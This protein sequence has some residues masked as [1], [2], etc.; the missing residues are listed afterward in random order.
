MPDG[1]EPVTPIALDSCTDLHATLRVSGGMGFTDDV[2]VSV[3]HTRTVAR[4]CSR[5][6][7]AEYPKGS[8]ICPAAY[9][10][11]NNGDGDRAGC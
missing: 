7:G 11:V 8:K 10:S 5:D 4:S 6:C 2:R 3:V 1:R 9:E